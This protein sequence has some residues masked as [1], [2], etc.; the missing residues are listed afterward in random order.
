MLARRLEAARGVRTTTSV[1]FAA[2]MFCLA[3][4]TLV[5]NE[6]R[7]RWRRLS[8]ALGSATC[9][10]CYGSR[11]QHVPEERTLPI[12]CRLCQGRG[13]IGY[14]TQEAVRYGK[15]LLGYRLSQRHSQVYLNEKFVPADFRSWDEMEHGYVWLNQWP[16]AVI[17]IAE[18]AMR[19]PARRL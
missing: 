8:A 12:P 2:K 5:R 3:L 9:P 17:E 10:H 6:V 14:R 7:Y 4:W 13:R 19:T 16:Q 18:S 15:A 1:S 11:Y